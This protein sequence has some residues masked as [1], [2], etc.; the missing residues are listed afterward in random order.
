MKIKKPKKP[1]RKSLVKE[2]DRVFSLFIRARDK[3]CVT[4][5][6]SENLTC[7]HLFSRVA[8]ST[9]WNEDNCACQCAG[10]NLRHEHDPYVFHRWF[11]RKYN[12]EYWDLLHAK[13]NTPRKFTDAELQAMIQKYKEGA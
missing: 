13:Y 6:T 5:G 3:R 12:Q 9:R 11:I 4:C 1:A 10:C 8:Y 7:G 2:L